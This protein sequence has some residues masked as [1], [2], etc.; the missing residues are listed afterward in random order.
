MVAH[1]TGWATGSH[2]PRPFCAKALP[3][4]V[5]AA[6]L[7]LELRSTELAAFAALVLV[8]FVLRPLGTFIT[9]FPCVGLCARTGSDEMANAQHAF[10]SPPVL[11]RPSPGMAGPS[12]LMRAPAAA[13]RVHSPE[14]SAGF[15]PRRSVP[16]WRRIGDV[17]PRKQ[18][19]PGPSTKERPG[20]VNCGGITRYHF[21]IDN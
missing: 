4:A 6:L 5:F 18:H 12:C 7:D 10:G 9:P 16:R 1:P 2:L 14:P 3:A 20:R 8:C 21:R 13:L 15:E 19:R 17:S 11:R